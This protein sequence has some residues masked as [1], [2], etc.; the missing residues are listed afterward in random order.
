MSH[1]SIL[2]RIGEKGLGS[3]PV[4]F[5]REKN[6]GDDDDD[7]NGDG[8]DG[9]RESDESYTHTHTHTRHSILLPSEND[10]NELNL[11]LSFS[12][13][14]WLFLSC[15]ALCLSHTGFGSQ[16]PAFWHL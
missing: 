5:T 12:A 14:L 9:D 15:P 1:S 2:S 8:D 7:S 6:Y 11:P 4:P 13:S 16:M 10:L 3:S